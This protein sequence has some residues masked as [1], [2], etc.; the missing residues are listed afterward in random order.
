M[1][2]FNVDCICFEKHKEKTY[3][4]PKFLE[5]NLSGVIL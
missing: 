5:S 3:L 2:A 4:Q 1:F